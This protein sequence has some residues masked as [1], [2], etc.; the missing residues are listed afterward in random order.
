[1]AVVVCAHEVWM[2]MTGWD[3][4]HEYREYSNTAPPWRTGSTQTCEQDIMSWWW[5]DRRKLIWQT[6]G[7]INIKMMSYWYRDYIIKM[8][9]S[10]DRLIFI[11]G[12]PM[13][14]R[15]SLY[16]ISPPG[17]S[18]LFISIFCKIITKRHHRAHGE[19][20]GVLCEYKIWSISWGHRWDWTVVTGKFSP[21]TH[22]KHLVAFFSKGSQ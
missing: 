3:T 6:G 13:L 11:M 20:Q 15:L 9:W 2:L 8:T 18:S 19:L 14:A 22:N 12:I 7:W 17:Q 5:W 1:M 4:A 16:W 21:N 10:W